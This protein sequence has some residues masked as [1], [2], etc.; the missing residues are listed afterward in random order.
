M[1]VQWVVSSAAAVAE[2]ITA[3]HRA[4]K[5]AGLALV[6]VAGDSR[7]DNLRNPLYPFLT[8]VRLPLPLPFAPCL[9][10][11]ELL[12]GV[13]K[14]HPVPPLAV[15]PAGAAGPG[16]RGS[17]AQRALWVELDGQCAR[18]VGSV[19]ALAER[20]LV[21]K[22]GFV[23]D[24]P[25]DV[26]YDIRTSTA[27]DAFD[28][29]LAASRAEKHAMSEAVTAAYSVMHSGD[30]VDREAALAAAGASG[31]PGAVRRRK[32]RM[33]YRQYLNDRG[34]AFV[35]AVPGAMVWVTSTRV[36][37]YA[38]RQELAEVLRRFRATCDGIVIANDIVADVADSVVDLFA[39]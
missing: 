27:V 6:Q 38:R 35:R 37:S 2:F 13:P 22:F 20:A 31:G 5:S 18:T 30:P 25:G 33:Y 14:P 32:R 7:H 4:A 29:R 15:L 24:F 3:L 10:E 12:A 1:Q 16:V 17:D 28:P 36:R 9:A 11:E 26:H 39:P 23:P 21:R 8:P 34:D 19:Q